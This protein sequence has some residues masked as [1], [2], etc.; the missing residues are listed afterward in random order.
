MTIERSPSPAATQAA[1][2]LTSELL[3]Y[4]LLRLTRYITKYE[5]EE[6]A[7][8]IAGEAVG[9]RSRFPYDST[10]QRRAAVGAYLN[11]NTVSAFNR[12]HHTFE[13]LGVIQQ[14]SGVISKVVVP[15]DKLEE[16]L[17]QNVFENDPFEFSVY[18]FFDCH[19]QA[20]WGSPSLGLGTEVSIEPGLEER[21]LEAGL[22]DDTNDGRVWS[23]LLLK[24]TSPSAHEEDVATFFGQIYTLE[25]ADI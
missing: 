5:Y 7:G 19:G 13:A 12:A 17:D 11:G 22:L 21:F 15:F 18:H 23:Q 4:L 16:H 25:E 20:E 8:S 9:F 14:V 24:Y 2:K 6:L 3:G 10:A 1:H